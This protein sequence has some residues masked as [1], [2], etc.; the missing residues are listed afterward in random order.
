ML[1]P[2]ASDASDLPVLV[3]DIGEEENG[4]DNLFCG[5]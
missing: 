1:R 5:C 4:G 3:P 2:D